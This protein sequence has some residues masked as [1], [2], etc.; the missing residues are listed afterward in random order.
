MSVALF[1]VGYYTNWC[2]LFNCEHEMEVIA[3]KLKSHLIL[4]VTEVRHQIILFPPNRMM[5]ANIICLNER[6][7]IINFTLYLQT[8]QMDCWVV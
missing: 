3:H 8:N 2:Y 6:Y 7:Y 5:Q 1:K 4:L